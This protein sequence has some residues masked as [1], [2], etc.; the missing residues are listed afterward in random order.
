MPTRLIHLSDLHF[1]RDR[2]EL[3]R[4]LLE[5]VNTLRPDIVAISGDLTQRALSSQFRAARTFID[6]IDAP[7]LCVPGNHDLPVHRPFRRFFR[8]FGNYKKHIDRD[9]SPAWMSPDLAVIGINTMSPWRWQTGWATRREIREAAAH[10]EQGPA[11]RLNVIVAHHP[12]QTPEGSDKKDMIN[13]DWGLCTLA[14][15]GADIIL[16]G[17]LHRWKVIEPSS[18]QAPAVLQI[19]CGTGL[20]TR[21][22]GEENDFAV[23]DLGEPQA[24]SH[25]SITRWVAQPDL[26]F[27]PAQA[28]KFL[29]GADGWQSPGL[30][31]A[32]DAVLLA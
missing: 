3:M 27:A 13:A 30:L 6:H 7:V 15:A 4:P 21:K 23:I 14:E 31:P 5:A 16:S 11:A 18:P 22:R 9:L 12:F 10:C 17:H 2:P 29:R 1:G 24:Q 8:R 25:L 20:S 26:S 19:H 32:T 28:Q